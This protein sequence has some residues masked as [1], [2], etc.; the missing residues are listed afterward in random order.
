MIYVLCLLQVAFLL[1]AGLGEVLLMGGQPVYLLVPLAKSALLVVLAAKTV[2]GR[3]WAMIG[4]VGVQGVTLAGFWIQAAAGVLPW[5]DF[6]VNLVGLLTNLALP[7]TVLYLAVMLF[8][9]A[10]AANRCA[11]TAEPR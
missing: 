4:L 11:R 7:A 1:L 10:T 9:R 5:V 8:S 6:T 2:S 3:R